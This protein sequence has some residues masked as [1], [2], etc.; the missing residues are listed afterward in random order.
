VQWEGLTAAEA[1]WEEYG[2]LQDNYPSRHLQDKL[3]FNG[4]GKVTYAKGN[5]HKRTKTVKPIAQMAADP[6]DK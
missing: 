5:N 1:T 4:E 3:I 6:N 2:I